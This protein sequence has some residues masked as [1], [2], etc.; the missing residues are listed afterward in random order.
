MGW[1]E[2]GSHWSYCIFPTWPSKFF[3]FG[4]IWGL[5]QERY[6]QKLN[7][8]RGHDNHHYQRRHLSGKQLA[9]F[10]RRKFVTRQPWE[11]RQELHSSG[12][13]I[14]LTTR[15]CCI[16]DR[17]RFEEENRVW[18]LLEVWVQSSTVRI[19]GQESG[20]FKNT[21]YVT[22]FRRNR[23]RRGGSQIL[24]DRSEDRLYGSNS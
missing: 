17:M 1:V 12:F 23:Q 7:N 9:L 19:S 22:G 5:F 18:L 21:C 3:V 24:T 13:E 6:L 14:F 4:G 15:W 8:S 11:C 10:R 2:K 20:S 16:E